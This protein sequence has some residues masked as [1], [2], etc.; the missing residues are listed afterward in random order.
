MGYEPTQALQAID[1]HVPLVLL[2]LA[3]ALGFSFV[4]FVIALRMARRQGVYVEPFIGAAVFFW[5]D[6]SFVLHWPT[7]QAV[8]GGHWWLKFWSIGL[9][10]TVALEAY[11]IWQFIHYGHREIL[12]QVSRPA[13]TVMTLAAVLGTGAM[14]WLVKASLNDPLYFVTFAITAI[15]STPF[16]TGIMLR[17]GNTAGQS[18][19]M[20]VCVML[21]FSGVSGAIA[22]AAP[23]FRSP[24]Y[25]AFYAT[26]MIWPLVNIWLIRRLPQPASGRAASSFTRSGHALST[27]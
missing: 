10:G 27:T 13:F 2:C 5:H 17:R 20:N 26:F 6:L 15:W 22:I 21:L 19:A 1:G 25:A 4:Y 18:V 24:V 16:H 23:A 14:W 3:V 9:C 12:P 11:L 8:Y 7:W